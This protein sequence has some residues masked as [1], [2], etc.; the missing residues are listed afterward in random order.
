[1]NIDW[2]PFPPNGFV[3]DRLATEDDI[4]AGRA[5]FV[6]RGPAGEVVG[7]PCDL[8]VPRLGWLTRNGERHVGVVIQATEAGGVT[9][10]GVREADG[11][12]SACTPDE[13]ESAPWCGVYFSKPGFSLTEAQPL[14]GSPNFPAARRGDVLAVRYK[15]G[16]V[17]FVQHATGEVARREAAWFSRGTDHEAGMR[18]CDSVFRISFLDLDEVLDEIN[19][20]IHVQATLADATGGYVFRSW[21][22]SLDG[23]GE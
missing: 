8:P 4:A 6:V 1:M 5:A 19:T 9:A 11:N 23:P 18:S 10:L 14:L 2:P 3:S 13:F 15:N 20:L 22:E 17:L 12:L 21:N 7:E 16:P